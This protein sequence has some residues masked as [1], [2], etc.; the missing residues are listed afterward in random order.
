MKTL[1]LKQRINRYNHSVILSRSYIYSLVAN[2]PFSSYFNNLKEDLL[3]YFFNKTGRDLAAFLNGIPDGIEFD[4]QKV[5]FEPADFLLYKIK[6]VSDSE[7]LFLR[8][9]Y[10]LCHIDSLIP[11]SFD[12]N[13]FILFLAG[14]DQV[15]LNFV[16]NLSHLKYRQTKFVKNRSKIR[17]VNDH[18]SEKERYRRSSGLYLD[19]GKRKRYKYWRDNYSKR[20]SSKMIILKELE[21]FYEES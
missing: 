20:I 11:E 16:A 8:D 3:T 10:N 13:H 1:T 2:Q 12:W 19:K 21:V 5:F 9:M 4:S 7:Y 6:F 17:Y 18:V 15:I 14:F